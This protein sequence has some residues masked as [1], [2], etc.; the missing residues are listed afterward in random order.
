M[1]APLEF[2]KPIW[3]VVSENAKNLIKKMLT[4]NPIERLS[5][6]DVVKHPWFASTFKP[7]EN[8][9]SH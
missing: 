8:N 7:V 4:R 6:A 5:A 9:H 1:N 2:K 3:M